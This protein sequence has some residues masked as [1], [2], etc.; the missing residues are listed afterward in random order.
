MRAIP[1]LLA[2]A[3]LGGCMTAEPEQV[4]RSARG[5]ETLQKLIAGHSARPAVSCIP[6][7][8]SDDMVVID[9][10]TVA[11]RA[12]STVYVNTL[13]S[14]CSRL[15]APGYALVTRRIGGT[16]MCRGE[17]ATVVDTSSGMV[18]GACSLGDFVP[19]VRS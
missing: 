6:D 3:S 2:T 13:A 8:R 17:I 7:Y 12:G 19:Y 14:P 16:G 5:Q 1:L 9:E 15:G 4:Q 18:A 11:F 10:Q